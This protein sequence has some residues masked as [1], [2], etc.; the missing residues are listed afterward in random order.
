MGLWAPVSSSSAVSGDEN[1]CPLWLRQHRCQ[2]ADGRPAW[3]WYPRA[4]C[5][6]LFL[7]PQRGS[8]NLAVLHRGGRYFWHLPGCGPPS[9]VCRKPTFGAK[10]TSSRWHRD[11]GRGALRHPVWTQLSLLGLS[12]SLEV[13]PRQVSAWYQEASCPLWG[14]A[15][16]HG[17]FWRRTV[18]TAT[19]QCA[20][21]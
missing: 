16:D 11:S 2:T 19:Q 7:Q 1:P 6:W 13:R 9:R 10:G 3:P 17:K 18:V 20:C 12:W 5:L 14:S 21:T 15:W 8:Q 4:P